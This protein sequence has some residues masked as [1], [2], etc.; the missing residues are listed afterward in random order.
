[1]KLSSITF[2]AAAS[3]AV[4][5]TFASASLADEILIHDAKSSPESLSAA[6]D[7]SLIVG[8]ASSPFIYRVKAGSTTAETFFDASADGPGTFFFGIM[9]DAP[10]N[11][12]WACELTPV[13][14][15][16][17]VVRKSQVRSFDLNTGAPKI[18][19]PLPGDSSTCNDFTFGPDHAM[20]I[21]DTGNGRIYKMAPGAST[22]DLFLE[23]RLL[24]GIDGITFL[25]GVMYVNSVF[26][27]NVYRIPVDASGKVGNPVDIWM[28]APV[29]GPD[30]MRAANGKIFVAENGAGKI[31]ALTITGDTAHVEVVKDGLNTPTAVEPAG[32]T[33]WIANRGAGQVVSVPM[34]K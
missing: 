29:K 32:D 8:S 20:Y 16:K 21:A 27:N 11:T 2:R 7:G 14:D 24:A 13:P 1:M 17:P 5:M 15:T 23:H 9:V 12:V 6:P 19:W 3:L 25:D 10:N 28:D 30:G 18:T 33:L 26:Y 22:A 34:P 31:S 4:L